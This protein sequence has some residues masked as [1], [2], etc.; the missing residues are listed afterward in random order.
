M[1]FNFPSYGKFDISTQNYEGRLRY[2]PFSSGFFIGLSGGYHTVTGQTTRSISISSVTISAT[3]NAEIK[4]MYVVPHMGWFHVAQNGFTIGF[5]LGGYI[6]LSSQTAVS[7]SSSNPLVNA[8][9]AT[10]DYQKLQADAEKVG[11]QIGGLSLPF[12]TLLRLGWSF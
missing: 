8:A 3:A 5:E 9:T 11:N 1:A 7:I 12:L 4:G 6:P 2:H 10:T